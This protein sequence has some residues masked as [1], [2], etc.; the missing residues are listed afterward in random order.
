M[1]STVI[2]ISLPRELLEQIDETAAAEHRTRSDLLREA[3]RRYMSDRRWRRIQA[4]VSARARTAGLETE[5]DVE[6]LMD[7]LPD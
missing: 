3:A 2:N 7:S 6:E 5:D 4:E 1:A